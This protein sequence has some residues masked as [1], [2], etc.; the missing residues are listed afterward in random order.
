[1]T[2]RDEDLAAKVRDLEERVQKLEATR[3]LDAV[4]EQVLDAADSAE[5]A[6]HQAWLERGER[7][8]T[9]EHHRKAINAIVAKI[10][11]RKTE[12]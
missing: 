3:T 6:Y 1:M 5:I 9:I 8:F 10:K 2:Y 4:L 11:R 7:E 12:K